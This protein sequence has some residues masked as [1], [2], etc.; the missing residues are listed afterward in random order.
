MKRARF[1]PKA[2]ALLIMAAMTLLMQTEGCAQN[3]QTGAHF[4][5]G[6]PQN[7]FSD[8]VENIGIGGSGWA[9]YVFGGSPVMLGM[10]LSYLIYGRETRYEPFSLTIPDVTVD[11]TNTNSIFMWHAFLR[12][13]ANREFFQPYADGLFGFKYLFTRTSIKS[14]HNQIEPIATSTNLDD[15]ALSYGV[16]GGLRFNVYENYERSPDDEAGITEVL[17]DLR[18]RYLFGAEAEYLKKGSIRRVG[19][20][21]VYDVQNSRTD[22]LSIQIGVCL[23]FSIPGK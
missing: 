13:Q 1:V 11:V 12:L 18:C 19:G 6:I 20:G 15:F 23:K 3:L 22:L 4:I 7:E 2:A 10:E 14:E 17:I 5:I 9:G 8:N 21:V 16:G